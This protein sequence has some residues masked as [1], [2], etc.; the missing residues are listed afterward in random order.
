MDGD[1]NT[2]DVLIAARGLIAREEDWSSLGPRGVRQGQRCAAIA[3]NDCGFAGDGALR[4]FAETI[5]SDSIGEWNDTHS[6]ADV[7]AAFDRAIAS[8]GN[9]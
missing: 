7:L 8:L 6:H 9:G 5:G 2:R 4:V 1:M 3:I